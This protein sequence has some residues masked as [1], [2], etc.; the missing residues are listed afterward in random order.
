MRLG[1][2]FV[3]KGLSI[4]K[5]SAPSPVRQECLRNPG[6]IDAVADHLCLSEPLI[7]CEAMGAI[8]RSLG[9]LFSH[10]IINPLE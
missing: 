10:H 5:R 6:G 4:F 1:T 7:E 3:P 8:F 2:V 9:R